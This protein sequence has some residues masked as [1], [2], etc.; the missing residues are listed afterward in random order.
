[1]KLQ[2]LNQDYLFFG[3]IE[4]KIRRQFFETD[5]L[6]GRGKVLIAYNKGDYEYIEKVA[7]KRLKLILYKME[8]EKIVNY[9]DISKFYI[10]G[11]IKVLIILLT[12]I[13]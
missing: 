9:F 11:F 8:K 7:K 3:N 4:R 6:L 5:E 13:L 1:M 12:H 2:I 10:R